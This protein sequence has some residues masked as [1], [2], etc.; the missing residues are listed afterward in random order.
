MRE[1]GGRWS[2][3]QV[4]TA[5][6]VSHRTARTVATAGYITPENLTDKDVVLLRVAAAL[7]DGPRPSGTPRN[8]AADAL[9]QRN[10]EALRLTQLV[11]NDPAP[12]KDVRL[13]VLPQTA[14]LAQD[15]FSLMGIIGDTKAEPLLLLPVGEWANELA[16]TIERRVIAT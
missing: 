4:A 9:I 15:A 11:L 16:G 8:E 2:L 7:L 1:P 13:A 10:F 12:N 3:T 6:G 5:A 14:R